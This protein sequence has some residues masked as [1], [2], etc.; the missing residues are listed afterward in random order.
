LE[1]ALTPAEVRKY[2]PKIYVCSQQEGV[3]IITRQPTDVE[4]EVKEEGSFSF[5]VEGHGTRFSPFRYSDAAPVSPYYAIIDLWFRF[6]LIENSIV[7]IQ[8]NDWILVIQ[9]KGVVST[10]GHYTKFVP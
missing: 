6:R 3:E 1:K 2:A 9:P 4:Y 10:G 5:S 8:A 7:F